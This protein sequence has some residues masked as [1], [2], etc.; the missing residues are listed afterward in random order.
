MIGH[1]PRRVSASEQVWKHS[2]AIITQ[3]R[4]L[5][6]ICILI[7]CLRQTAATLF[8]SSSKKKKPSDF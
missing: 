7:V 5:E 4:V 6:I 3:D 2:M 8:V 1:R